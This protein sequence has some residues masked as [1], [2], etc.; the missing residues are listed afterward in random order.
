ML[1]LVAV[2]AMFHSYVIFPWLLQWMAIGK[3]LPYQRYA[4]NHHWP[5]IYVLFSV[6]NEEKVIVQKIESLFNTAY[7]AELLEVYIGS[8]C[9]TDTTNDLIAAQLSRFPQ[10]RLLPYQQ[11][12]GKAGVLNKLTAEMGL[13]QL[14]EDAILVLTDANVMFHP[15]TLHELAAYF[16]DKRVGQVGANVINRISGEGVAAQEQQYISRE[17]MIKYREG[18]LWGAMQG[19]F[20]ACYAVRPSLFPQ[21]P[22]NFLMEDFYVSMNV[23]QQGYHAILNPE[24]LCEEDVPG[25]VKEEFK[26]KTRISTGN[27]QNLMVYWRILFHER[28]VGFCFLSHKVLRWLGPLWL[29]MIG[30]GLALLAPFGIIWK[31][32]LMGYILTIATPL[33]DALLAR[34]GWHWP[35][36]RLIAYFIAMNVA[37]ALGFWR[38]IRGVQSGA[39]SPTKRN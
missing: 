5:R 33:A 25:D 9:S 20:G 26:R 29:L 12:S 32:L 28:Y 17:N 3:S 14:P 6:F 37:L 11:R 24:A 39:W 21:L 10:L 13:E 34:W 35:L 36:L 38:Y 16:S 15:E 2:L 23:L 4:A 19:A 8:D 22:G 27:I 31:C 1:L 18:L 7:P 30:V